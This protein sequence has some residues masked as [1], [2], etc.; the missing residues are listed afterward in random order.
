[1][2]RYQM[3]CSSWSSSCP[4]TTLWRH[5]RYH[6]LV[7][8]GVF[9][10]YQRGMLNALRL[11]P[12]LAGPLLEQ[13]VSPKCGQTG[14]DLLGH[15]QRQ[16]VTRATGGSISELCNVIIVINSS[17][18]GTLCAVSQPS[19]AAAYTALHSMV[20]SACRHTPLAWQTSCYSLSVNLTTQYLTR[21]MCP[22]L[23]FC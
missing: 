12:R 11:H 3:V 18:Q 10:L 21:C 4:L 13:N 19:N 16:V 7:R 1:M 9:M 22:S 6:Y 8:T 23:S 5:R 14:Q 15:P 17:L 20:C 2:S